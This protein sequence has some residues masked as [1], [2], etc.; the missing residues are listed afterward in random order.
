MSHYLDQLHN[1]LDPLSQ[2]ARIQNN[3]TAHSWDLHNKLENIE[4][5]AE[6]SPYAD[7][8]KAIER[9]RIMR[10]LSKP[11]GDSDDFPVY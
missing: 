5:L 11:V 9:S 3:H 6:P 4:Q 10:V 7:I 2:I 1:S 8:V